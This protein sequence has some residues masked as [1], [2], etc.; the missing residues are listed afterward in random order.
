MKTSLIRG[1]RDHI[2]HQKG[3]GKVWH[4]KAGNNLPTFICRKRNA[5]GCINTF[6]NVF[7]LR[8]RR[9]SKPD[10]DALDTRHIAAESRTILHVFV[11]FEFY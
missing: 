9:S 10:I 1:P 6:R 2:L 11:I 7:L 4:Q 3:G 5:S 8:I